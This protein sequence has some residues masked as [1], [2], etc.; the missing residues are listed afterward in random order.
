MNKKAIL[1]SVILSLIIF[2]SILFGQEPTYRTF[3]QVDFSQKKAKAG[4]VL[5]SNVC[6]HFINNSGHT[7]TSLH[8]KFNSAIL[9][10]INSGG[11]S[12]VTVDPKGKEIN[13][14]GNVVLA[15]GDSI[16]FCAVFA[17]KAPGTQVNFGWWDSAGARVGPRFEALLSW[18]DVQNYSQPNGGTVREYLYKKVITRPAG[19]VVGI[20][21]DTPNV[22][23]IRYLK[24]DRKY[25]PHTGMSRCLDFIESGSGKPIV[26][27]KQNL[28]VKKHDNHLLGELP[29]LKL[30]IIANDSGI[31]EPLSGTALGDLIYN[32]L[33]NPS[34]PCNGKT[35]RQVAAYADSALTYCNHFSEA[36]SIY[37]SLD[38]CISRINYAFDGSYAAVSFSPF[39]VAGTHTVS[40]SPYLH[41]NPAA[42]P[43]AGRYS[44]GSLFDIQPE[45]FEIFQNYPNPFNPATTIQFD[46]V[47]PAIVT[48]KVYNLLGQEVATLLDREA[49]E[50]GKQSV[51]F[52][53]S[54][55]PSGVYLYKIVALGTG[56]TGRLI[57]AVK[58]MVLIK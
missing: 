18:S 15:P 38:S 16:E 3:N 35:L 47:D 44:T 33:A 6:F 8:A 46:L 13:A 2:S 51:E 21:T 26:G 43:V 40:E 31:T 28:H 32:D 53:A 4:K 25:F 20:A 5:S 54:N 48:L 58:K 7:T 49:V 50:D 34:D 12:N 10:I 27:E 1:V 24:A 29:L 55:L 36:P 22:G 14:N 45:R 52:D 41:P 39:L 23:W 19:L 56:E 30:A 42:H 17:K 57:Q 37:A 9:S 11:Y